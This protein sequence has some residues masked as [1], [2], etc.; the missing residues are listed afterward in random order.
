MTTASKELPPLLSKVVAEV[1]RTFREDHTLLSFPEYFSLL[2]E[3]PRRHLRASAQYLVDLFDHYGQTEVTL[4]TGKVTRFKL[5][6]AP[7]AGGEGR[8]AGQE[9]VQETLYRLLANFAREGRV[10]KMILLHGPNGSAKSSLTRCVMAG[11]EAYARLPEGALYSFNWIFPSERVGH[12][13]LG[14]SGASERSKDAPRDSSSYAFLPAEDVDARVPCEMHDHP[15]F[16]IPQALRGELLAKLLPVPPENVQSGR[17]TLAADYLR[18]GDLCYKCRRIYDALLA[19]YDGD[20]ERVLQHVQV[21][22]V[23][24]SKR[25]RRGIATVEPQMSVDARIQQVTADRSMA[26]LPVA[27]QHTSLFEPSG[28]LVDANRGLLEF[29]DLLK[30]PV[31]T[32][33]YLLDTVETANVSMDSFVLHLDLIYLASTN[34]SYLEAF[35]QHPD[36]PSFKGRMELLRVPYVMRYST[37]QEI[38]APQ[39]H[40]R[41]VGKHVAP[42][43][44]DVAALWAILTRMRRNDAMR[45]SRELSSVVDGLTPLEKLKLYDAGET[46]ERLTSRQARELESA[47]PDLYRESQSYPNYEGRFGASARELRTAL[48]NAAHHPDYACLHPL[49]VL[50]ELAELLTMKSVYEFLKQEVVG[51]FHDHAAFLEETEELYLKWIDDEV[52]EATGLASEQSY[53]ELFTRYINHVSHWVKKEKLAD[54]TSRTGFS[55]PDEKLMHEVERVLMSENENV[56][57]FRRALISTIGARALEHPD[58]APDYSVIFKHH[59]QRLREDFYHKRKK[60]LHKLI[61]NF[62]KFTAREKTPLDPK[63]REHA[64]A[65][66]THL[67]GKLGYCEQCA[68]DTVAYLLRKRYA[69]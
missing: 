66:L 61:E 27:L 16:L 47:I 69:E 67:T 26:S 14:F 21:E 62:L 17:T 24:L 44:I 28:P 35:K 48:L 46:P 4:P 52:R 33:K 65:M 5:F 56:D 12:S 64:Q 2:S 63:D 45:Y 13:T 39:I 6:D 19:S 15:I 41:V 55:N 30:R 29:S 37:E 60:V 23:Y 10:N 54:P 57:D 50:G 20:I 22:R 42:H 51:K 40:S 38:Y 8:V 3:N 7:F 68:R 43:A 36:F 53:Q 25:Y 32:F 34:E 59:Q 1:K 9:Q 11:M 49:A 58:Q 31:E 18:L